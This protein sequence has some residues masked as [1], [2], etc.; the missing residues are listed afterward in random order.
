[1]FSNPNYHSAELLRHFL[2]GRWIY[3]ADSPVATPQQS[4]SL[5]S[6]SRIDAQPRRQREGTIAENKSWR[7]T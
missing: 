6:P 2:A 3:D 1:M 4:L 5:R 7:R